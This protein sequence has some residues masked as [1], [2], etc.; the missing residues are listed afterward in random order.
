MS[1][2]FLR[3]SFG[4]AT[5]LIGTAMLVQPAMAQ[6]TAPMVGDQWSFECRSNDGSSFQETY[7]VERKDGDNIRVAVDSAGASNWY[8][9]PFYLLPTTLASEESASRHKGTISSL[10][11]EFEGLKSLDVGSQF[12]EWV[13]ERRPNDRLNWSYKISVVGKELYYN[14]GQGDLE[15]YAIDEQRY[16]G[17]YTS[18]L[19]SYYSPKLR[20][21]VYWEYSDSNNA[22]IECNLVTASLSGPTPMASTPATQS[23]PNPSET[24]YA[25]ALALVA[26]TTSNI[27]SAPSTASTRLGSVTAGENVDALAVTEANG[28]RWYRIRT[29]DG[30]SGYVFAPLLALRG[31]TA[32][33]A[34]VIAPAP[35]APAPAAAPTQSASA[36][37][38]PAAMPAPTVSALPD[39]D[40]SA[41]LLELYKSGLLTQEE[42]TAKQRELQGEVAVGRQADELNDI[43]L[44]FRRGELTPDKFMQARANVLDTINPRDMKPKEALTLLEQLLEAKLI[45]RTEYGRKRQAIIDAI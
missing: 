42:Y 28:E 34:P 17:L 18:K 15:V 1:A 16:T 19:L 25:T 2:T 43:N 7:R 6:M 38:A 37:P 12:N 8:E 30:Q 32:S 24:L 44:R 10:P 3:A 11:S 45:S 9:K 20:F 21:P 35:V 40:R 23:V 26:S 36:S 14:P 22:G 41:R 33:A 4:G 27:R 13:V 5:V 39:S 29:P 31:Q